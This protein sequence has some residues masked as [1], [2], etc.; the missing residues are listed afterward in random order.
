MKIIILKSENGRITSENIVEGKLSEV[1]KEVAAKAL[2]EWNEAT[3]DFVIMKDT[4]DVKIPKPLKPEIYEAVKNFLVGRDENF[5]HAKLPLYIISYENEWSN[6]NFIDKKVYIVSY[7]V[8]D[9]N[10]KELEEYAKDIT[11]PET[12]RKE[13]NEEE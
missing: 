2:K 6:D 9:D 4:Q 3:S 5:A 8:N 7:Y 11:S 13:S 12:E 10:K 1:L